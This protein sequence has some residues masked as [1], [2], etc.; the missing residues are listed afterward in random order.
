MADPLITQAQLEA[1][2]S[3]DA[4]SR[5]Y[6][7]NSDGVA[8]SEPLLQLRKDAS[9]KVRSKLGPSVNVDNL[10]PATHDEVV[11]ITLDV[12]HAMAAQRF[13]EVLRI[14]GFALM[15]QAEKDLSE[16]RTGEADLG[17]EDEDVDVVQYGSVVSGTPRDEW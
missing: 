5:I 8:D 17:T 13:P 6:D 15:R 11:R 2:L 1:R 14:D 4:V 12:A 16:I 10:D 9:S 3:S 7:D